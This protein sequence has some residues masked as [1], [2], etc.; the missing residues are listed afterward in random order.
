[1][2]VKVFIGVA[3][4]DSVDRAAV[5]KLLPHEIVLV[6]V[7]RGGLNINDTES[8]TIS[9]IATAT[10]EALYEIDKSKFKTKS[11]QPATH[12]PFGKADFSAML[13]LSNMSF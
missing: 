11:N 3:Q 9:V 2:R 5:K 12:C 8:D 6:D 1:M 7:V 4:P 10:V 13:S